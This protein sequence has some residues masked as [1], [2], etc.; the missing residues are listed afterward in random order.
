MEKMP[1]SRT[2]IFLWTPTT[3]VVG[4]VPVGH[5]RALIHPVSN[6]NPNLQMQAVVM[7]RS[8]DHFI[9]RIR[10]TSS[11]P[12]EGNQNEGKAAPE[13]A[14][15]P[16]PTF[17]HNLTLTHQDLVSA[18]GET[19]NKIPTKVNESCRISDKAI[20]AQPS[21]HKS[22]SEGVCDDNSSHNN[23]EPDSKAYVFEEK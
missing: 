5:G 22:S 2:Y 3:P 15:C 10:R 12:I 7:E 18:P 17:K 4:R 13:L 8:N 11:G 16:E 21:S 23:A 14:E 6:S 20:E 19:S 9:M 1:L